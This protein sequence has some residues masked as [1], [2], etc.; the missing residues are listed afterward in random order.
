MSG[1]LW[2]VDRNYQQSHAE[3]MEVRV[4]IDTGNY[5]T[6]NVKVI[7]EKRPSYV[8]VQLVLLCDCV[9]HIVKKE[10]FKQ[11]NTNSIEIVSVVF[12]INIWLY[13]FQQVFNVFK[14]VL[15]VCLICLK[16]K[17]FYMNEYKMSCKCFSQRTASIFLL[18]NFSFRSIVTR[19]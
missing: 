6:W 5:L 16:I 1:A 2:F 7:T 10:Q 4:N 8:W 13:H 17:N 14:T 11:T 9:P 12:A 15:F 3:T 18:C 19:Q